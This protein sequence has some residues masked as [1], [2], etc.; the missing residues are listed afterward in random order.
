MEKPSKNSVTQRQTENSVKLGKT[1][2]FTDVF[3]WFLLFFDFFR[4]FS[5]FFDFFSV[6]TSCGVFFF[7]F[8]LKKIGEREREKRKKR[9]EK[10]EKE[11]KKKKRL[12]DDGTFLFF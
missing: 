7:S 9:N 3:F 10:K 12:V 2:F 11:R 8:F 4:F 5:I 6:G 1:R